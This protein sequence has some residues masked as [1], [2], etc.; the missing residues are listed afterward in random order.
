[1]ASR[2][3]R[4]QSGP[5]RGL[6]TWDEIQ[7]RAILASLE[8]GAGLKLPVSN[9]RLVL[10]ELRDI[11]LIGEARG[12]EGWDKDVRTFL[13]RIAQIPW[14]PGKNTVRMFQPII[15]MLY[16]GLRAICSREQAVATLAVGIQDMCDHLEESLPPDRCS[17]V[18]GVQAEMWQRASSKLAEG[19]GLNAGVVQVLRHL[20]ATAAGGNRDMLDED[21]EASDYVPN[22][23]LNLQNSGRGAKSGS[24]RPRK[25]RT[26]SGGGSSAAAPASPASSEPG[27]VEKVASNPTVRRAVKKGLERAVEGAGLGTALEPGGGTALGGALGAVEGAVEGALDS[28]AAENA[29]KN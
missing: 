10:A 6:S 12:R 27:I 18:Y 5:P 23:L 15:G 9:M 16:T 25:V 7:G 2:V 21:D 4:K 13:S 20:Q 11:Y 29:K 3:V 22:E 26:T 24:V 1:M 28:D 8:P 14:D 17:L 19:A